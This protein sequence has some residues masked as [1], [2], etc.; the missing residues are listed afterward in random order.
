MT[1]WSHAARSPST[2]RRKGYIPV[3]LALESSSTIRKK[4]NGSVTVASM[5]ASACPSTYMARCCV[6]VTSRLL[7]EAS[8]GL[9]RLPLYMKAKKHAFAHVSP[10]LIWREVTFLLPEAVYRASTYMARSVVCDPM[11]VYSPSMGNCPSTYRARTLVFAVLGGLQHALTARWGIRPRPLLG[12]LGNLW[13]WGCLPPD[14]AFGHAGGWP[15][16][17]SRCSGVPGAFL[18][19][20]FDFHPAVSKISGGRVKNGHKLRIG[21]GSVAKGNRH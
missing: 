21:I 5:G 2:N 15:D 12:Y 10:L 16:G 1:F 4:R 17:R 19:V 8:M 20:L 13:R 6:Y 11:G 7:T 9:F 18:T 14:S 3:T